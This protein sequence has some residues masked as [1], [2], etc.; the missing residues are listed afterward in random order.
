MKGFRFK[1]LLVTLVLLIVVVPLAS[2][3]L[4]NAH[5]LLAQVSL[6]VLLMAMLCAAVFAVCENRRKSMIAVALALPAIVL[7]GLDAVTDHTGLLGASSICDVIFFSYVIT[8]ILR[9]LFL[10][11]EVTANVICA[12]LCVYLLLGVAWADI[13]SLVDI[14]EG[15]SF[16]YNL[17]DD[18]ATHST[19]RQKDKDNDSDSPDHRMR[20]RGQKAIYPIY[21]SFVTMTTLG[22][23]DIV[24]RTNLSRALVSIQSVMG[25][26]YLAVLVARLVGLHI[27]WSTREQ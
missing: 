17:G 26:L 20:L 13:Y 6:A 2:L 14:A 1:A 3:I 5:P 27:S 12:S 24:P 16:S 25:Q 22:Y 23:G 8:V 18:L 10:E 4:P 15:G 19:T 11:K 7:Q 9:H 21:F